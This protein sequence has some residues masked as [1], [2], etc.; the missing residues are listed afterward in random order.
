MVSDVTFIKFHIFKVKFF[1]ITLYL[2]ARVNLAI[3]LCKFSV[4]NTLIAVYFLCFLKESPIIPVYCSFLRF[5][6]IVNFDYI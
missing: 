6:Y 5:F 4:I 1:I 2:W 3:I